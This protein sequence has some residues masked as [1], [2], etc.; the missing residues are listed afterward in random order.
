MNR[1]S[2]A[3]R[4]LADFKKYGDSK[5]CRYYKNI[6]SFLRV[7]PCGFKD[8]NNISEF[9]EFIPLESR[10]G[11]KLEKVVESVLCF[12]VGY[13]ELLKDKSFKKLMLKIASAKW[14][15]KNKEK[16]K[17]QMREKYHTDTKYRKRKLKLQIADYYKD[18]EYRRIRYGA[19]KAEYQQKNKEK[20]YKYQIAWRKKNKEKISKYYK[21]YY[22]YK[23]NGLLNK[24]IEI[25]GYRRI[26]YDF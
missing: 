22:R 5:K 4:A 17:K 19:T 25:L 15:A 3:E 21:Q 13:S 1:T 26:N 9:Y 14:Y 16:Y 7:V 18:P 12:Y 20:I 11:V 8:K 23:K 10:R 6:I 2:M 24:K